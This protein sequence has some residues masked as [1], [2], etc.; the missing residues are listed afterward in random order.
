MICK[1]CQILLKQMEE[2]KAKIKMLEEKVRE[3]NPY[4]LNI[5]LRIRALEKRIKE[6]N[7]YDSLP[8]RR[9]MGLKK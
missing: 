3:L 4:G 2:D 7:A 8:V 6:L 9:T 5:K 1:N